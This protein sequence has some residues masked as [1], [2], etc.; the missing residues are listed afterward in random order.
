MRYITF[1]AVP[2]VLFLRPFSGFPDYYVVSNFYLRAAAIRLITLPD[3]MD[4]CHIKAVFRIRT[5]CPEMTAS[6]LRA[7]LR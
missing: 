6:A 7:L 3:F 2:A 1:A 5:V 4:V